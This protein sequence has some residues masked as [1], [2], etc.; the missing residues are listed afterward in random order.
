M[1]I[2]LVKIQHAQVVSFKRAPTGKAYSEQINSFSS[3]QIL[4]SIIGKLNEF[5]SHG[6]GCNTLQVD[7]LLS[8]TESD[9]EPTAGVV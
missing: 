5:D 7:S 8:K 3:R 6:A 2:R 1:Q 4:A 9:V